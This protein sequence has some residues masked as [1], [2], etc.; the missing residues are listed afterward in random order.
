MK[1]IIVFF[2]LIIA[3]PTFAGPAE[4]IA[5]LQPGHWYEITQSQD[6]T[7]S[8]T[9]LYV[10][11][12]TETGDRPGLGPQDWDNLGY[13]SVDCPCSFFPATCI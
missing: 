12:T 10:G 3:S 7:I 6:G 1:R 2:L 8:D 4:D 11:N 9:K 5:A 13:G